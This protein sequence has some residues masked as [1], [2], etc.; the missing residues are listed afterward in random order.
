MKFLFILVLAFP[1]GA[2]VLPNHYIVEL[3][4]EPVAPV[5]TRLHKRVLRGDAAL[6]AHRAAIHAEQREVRARLENA[7]TQVLDS[8]DTLHDALVVRMSPA[9][10]AEVRGMAGVSS[11][12]SVRIYHTLLD[13]SLP[14]QKVV[15]AWQQIGGVDR[16]GLG[17][18]IG[19][20]DTGIDA[21]HPAFQDPS[22][23]I[24]SGYPLL[25]K[26]TD[27]AFT[28][29][30]I[31]VARSYTNPN[32]RKDYDAHDK[33][34][35]GTGVAM[36][37]AGLANNGTYGP[38][39]GV[40]PKAW[41][42]NYK[43]FP[44]DGTGAPDSLIIR[45]IEDAVNDGMDVI[46]LSLGSFPATRPADDSLV[47][48]VE[49]AVAAGKIVVIAAG[50]D[51]SVPNTI[52]SPATAP[53]AISVGSSWN[54]RIFASRVLMDGRDP[55]IAL[56]GDGKNSATPITAA[57][58][59]VAS[60]DPTG[61]ACGALPSGSL[62]GNIALIL[63][64][65]CNF[66]V[67]LTNALDA[68]AVAAIIYARPESPDPIS[69][70]TSDV[71]L[72]A[73][74]ISNANGLA[75]Q[76]AS[77]GDS[78]NAT[79]DFKAAPAPV[80]SARLSDFSSRGPSSDSSIK[81]DL[82]AIGQNIYTAQPGTAGGG[83]VVVSGTSFSSPTVAGAAALLMAARPGL[84][85]QQ[86]RSLLVNST[87]A[88]SLDGVKPLGAQY[89]GSGLLNMTAALSNSITASPTSLS[90]GIG[91]GSVNGTQTLTVTNAGTAADTF[92][93]SVQP[94]SD[95]A[96]PTLSANTVQLAPGQSQS[97]GVQFSA[98][99]LSGGAYQGY[100]QI[101]GT[102]SSVAGRVPYWCAVPTQV[103]AF[104]QILHSPTTVRRG[105]NFDVAFRVVDSTGVPVTGG[106]TTAIVS[107]ATA[108]N[109][110]STDSDVPGSFLMHLQAPLTRGPLTL[111]FQLGDV[112]GS[113]VSITVN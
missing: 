77:A 66:S 109:V 38:I 104:I 41:L 55:F 69:M 58:K 59:D 32:T 42:G 7:D 26:S 30:K 36:V 12:R 10:A 98:D 113:P 46:N 8:F 9:R 106:I 100:L 28:N 96:A 44:D 78:L 63:R 67:K 94:A 22:L 81:P 93:L 31:I 87:S 23:T 60:L 53:S 62:S 6:L 40:A 105:N 51:G 57:V 11:V 79:V 88:F 101:Q 29:N 1:A 80:N 37:A 19:I 110:E 84:T 18:K 27:S 39:T 68:G 75:L 85:A 97:V 25:N 43:V 45:A 20:I 65:T 17:V 5:A 72:P 13:R 48:A 89:A 90:F 102:R 50:N 99:Q 86:Y 70:A 107:G 91:G 92:A 103:P 47:R 35:H 82:L 3:S 54:D 73:V 4:K 64:G 95:G 34:G 83:Y 15:D 76:S 111:Q 71:A 49:N 52:A 108:L 2:Q 61:L 14:L 74:M 33:D 56:P 21:S 24:P 112:N 16:A